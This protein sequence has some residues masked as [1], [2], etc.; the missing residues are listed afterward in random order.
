MD[1]SRDEAVLDERWRAGRWAAYVFNGLRRLVGLPTA[2]SRRKGGRAR[3]GR[4]WERRR[5]GLVKQRI[6]S[7]HD[8][9]LARIRELEE[10]LGV[11]EY[12]LSVSR[13]VHPAALVGQLAVD[14]PS[15]GRSRVDSR[16]DAGSEL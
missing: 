2:E 7:E 13:G 11:L 15:V 14:G 16:S 4:L 12:D 6:V 3:W 8:D 1:G 5:R 9:Q 10:Q